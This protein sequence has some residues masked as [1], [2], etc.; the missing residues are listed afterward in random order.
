[1]QRAVPNVADAC[2]HKITLNGAT[3]VTQLRFV[4]RSRVL[5]KELSQ[6]LWLARAPDN[7]VSDR[8]SL[9]EQRGANKKEIRASSRFPYQTESRN[10]MSKRQ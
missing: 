2:S 8:T 1:M 9:G 10:P 6:C 4:Y 7:R 3:M 5:F